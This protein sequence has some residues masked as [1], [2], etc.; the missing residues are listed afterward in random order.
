[1]DAREAH[2]LPRA[3][4]TRV[5]RRILLMGDVRFW[6][7][8]KTRP[9]GLPGENFKRSPLQN[10]MQVLAQSLIVAF[11]RLQMSAN[12]RQPPTRVACL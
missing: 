2:R 12:K 7:A 11:Q 4:K 1:M 10:R 6:N 5:A 9:S 8:K 3:C